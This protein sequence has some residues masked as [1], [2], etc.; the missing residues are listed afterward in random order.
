[1]RAFLTDFAPLLV[2]FLP[3]VLLIVLCLGMLQLS[4]S[5]FVGR[6]QGLNGRMLSSYVCV[7]DDNVV[8]M[9]RN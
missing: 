6:C 4:Y 9:T 3:L 8:L 7:D 5:D 1:M 2:L